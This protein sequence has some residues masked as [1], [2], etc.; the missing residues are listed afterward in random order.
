MSALLLLL[1]VAAADKPVV[2]VLYF[3]NRGG[4]AELDVLKKG[5]A[6]MLITDLV[7]WDGVTVVER[8]RLEDV[9]KE[10]SLQATRAFDKATA[11]KVG[12]LV[13][14]QFTIT[15]S[16]IVSGPQLRADAT[17]TRIEKGDVVASAS[18]T[19]SKDKVFELEQ[20][21]VDS[22]TAAI[23]WK[24]KN[25][26]ARKKA[27]VPSFD[28]LVA[29]SKAIDLSDQGK[30]DEAQKAM[31]AV[32]S[33]SPTF[34]MAREKKNELLEKLK[35]YEARKK[36]LVTASALEV[37]KRADDELKKGFA[38]L[39]LP[40][41][42]EYLFWRAAKG[43][44]LTRVLKQHLSWR[45]EGL[46]VIRPGH[47]PRALEALKGWAE[48][49]RR[50]I[51]EA[52]EL[53]KVE[54]GAS[55]DADR[56]PYR[57]LIR[58]SGLFADDLSPRFDSDLLGDTLEAFI[59]RGRVTDG[60][61]F[62]V[63]PPLGVLVP[64]E[65]DRVLETMAQDVA[66]AEAAYKRETNKQRAEYTLSRAIT[67]Q[68]ETLEWLRRDDDAAAAYQKLLD[69]LPTS[70]DAKS[71]EEKIQVIIGAKSTYDRDQREKFEKA[72]RDCDDFYVGP[73]AGWRLRRKGLA[74][75]DEIASEMEKA[76]LGVPGNT[77]P[78]SR[79]YDAL[80]S[81]AARHDD[82]ERSKKYYLKS[83]TFGGDGPR[84]FEHLPRNE[85]WCNLVLDETTLPSKVR[86]VVVK[87][88]TQ[89]NATLEAL[90]DAAEDLFVE[91]LAAR[92]VAV[93]WGGSSNG[94]VLGLGVQLEA[95]DAKSTDFK[96]TGWLDSPTDGA[97]RIELSAPIKGRVDFDAFFAP[98]L[99]VLKGR[100]DPG[101]R[102]PTASMPV[103][104]A[105]AYGRAMEVFDS[106]RWKEAQAA[107]EA[108]AKKY[109]GMRMA[110]ARAK[111]AAAKAEKN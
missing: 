102:K 109:P 1:A 50:F 99:K 93:E 65:T 49:Q 53:E 6:E 26:D 106:S 79:F 89:G 96:L 87:G 2:S 44:F 69:V 92:G 78:W 19:D 14:A 66:R 107:F 72:V 88:G 40:Q 104:Q 45:D 77:Y 8:S 48:N 80:A 38:G 68:G 51:D 17:I 30:V 13:G 29:Y 3:E 91:E 41:K 47:E 67:Q 28:A 23:D 64:A 43:R 63:A 83:F 71:A 16:L 103:E 15:G 52:R 57:E 39:T 86:I 24:L 25:R 32:V 12:R 21:L 11:V 98:A 55:F 10:Q 33:K 58:D 36:D 9:L 108:L 84:S 56:A 35:E 5:F 74:G 110:G 111:V 90:Q 20:K 94:G 73:E 7:A 76:C 81:D 62:D 75:L 105:A 70:S 85:P 97:P 54:Q 60:Q 4:D 46:R 31:A 18:A 100:S 34:S 59:I 61:T 37:G 22:L 101:P 95:K 82:C 27:R 42:K